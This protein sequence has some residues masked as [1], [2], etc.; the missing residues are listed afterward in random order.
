MS[1]PSSLERIRIVLCQPSHPGNIGAAARAM[2]TMGLTRLYLVAP[3]IFPDPQA[4]AM[5]AGAVDVLANARIC[6]SLAEALTGTVAATALTSRRRDLA[7]EPAWARPAAAQ[8]AAEAASGEVALVFGNETAGLSNEE[9]SLCRHWA[10]IPTDREFK[11]LNLAQAVQILCYELRM[12]AVDAGPPP[13]VTEAGAPA[14]HEE[15]EAL[16]GHLERAVIASGFLDPAKPKRLIPRM[17][18]MFARAGLEKEEVNIL[19]GMLSSFEK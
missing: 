17:R 8:L 14:S 12:A 6:A 18:R 19:R 13:T 1:L 9:L 7:T 5:A 10:L 2:K 16:I 15:V 11:S 4:T 3:K